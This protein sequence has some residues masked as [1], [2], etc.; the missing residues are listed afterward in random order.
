M[1]GCYGFGSKGSCRYELYQ[2]VT[3]Y[4]LHIGVLQPIG[5][6]LYIG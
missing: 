6:V 2:P 3:A 5:V 4:R 1:L